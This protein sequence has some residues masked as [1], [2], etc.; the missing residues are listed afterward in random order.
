MVKLY[1]TSERRGRLPIPRIEVS[2]TYPLG[3]FHAWSYIELQGETL[4]YPAPGEKQPTAD[5]PSYQPSQQGDKGVG[6]DDFVGLRSYRDGDSP[7]Q[8]DWKAHAREQGLHTKQFGGDRADSCWL[9]WDHYPHLDSEG[10]LSALCRGVLDA[11]EQQ[12]A[13][14]LRLPDVTLKPARGEQQRVKALRAL[15][16][17]GET[18]P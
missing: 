14:G 15:A 9:E 2:S 1:I 8:I 3:L 12:Q 13:F 4:V 7:K 5:L 17:F 10:R 11:V 18:A 16:L 6:A